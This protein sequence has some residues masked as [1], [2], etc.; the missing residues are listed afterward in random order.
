MKKP[1]LNLLVAFLLPA[2]TLAQGF[3]PSPV[4]WTTPVGSYTGSTGVSCG[5]FETNHI[6]SWYFEDLNGD[7]RP[8]LIVPTYVSG[9][10]IMMQWGVGSAPYW[11]VYLNTGSGFST[12]SITWNTPVGG[13]MNGSGVNTGYTD[14]N[15]DYT[16]YA[17][18][19][20]W[21]V[22]DMNDD[23]RP[24]LVV[25]S[26]TDANLISVQLG[27]GS[28]PHWKVYLNNGNG[29]DASPLTWPTPTGGRFDVSGS[30]YGYTYL[31]DLLGGWF[32]SERWNCMDMNGDNRPDLV[33]TSQFTNTTPD[34]TQPGA[35]L[36]PYWI[37]YY[38][39]GT[40]FDASGS[41]WYTPIGGYISTSSNSLGYVSTEFNQFGSAGSEDWTLRDMN[42]DH[43][44][45]LLVTSIYDAVNF[46]FAQYGAG[47]NPYWKV[48]YNTGNRFDT[49]T[50]VWS[51]PVGGFINSGGINFGYNETSGVNNGGNG[52]QVW[53]LC[54]LGGDQQPDLV[55]TSEFDFGS[56]SFYQFGT[57][58]S[59]YWKVCSNLGNGF[60][61][62]FTD[63][64]TPV[65]GMLISAVQ[66]P[67]Y[68]R[69][70]YNL[71]NENGTQVWDVADI[72]GDNSPD[73]IVT[74]E[75]QSA[76]SSFVQYNATTSPYWKVYLASPI[77][78]PE[79][80]TSENFIQAWPN[81]SPDV[82]R[83]ATTELKQPESV[84]V[85]DS[86]GR[87]VQAKNR[88]TESG[89]EVDLRNQPAGVYSVVIKH[90]NGTGHCRVVLTR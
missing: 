12:S 33:I 52:A 67:G 29:F 35:G 32:G 74:S 82:F 49:T 66:D 15:S 78:I 63:W 31:K 47:T 75:Y 28:S 13:Y 9:G 83:L 23:S 60:A 16:G 81:P 34:Y 38:N 56:G 72:N 5:F 20:T 68:F 3:S 87:Q 41:N 10:S 37:V 42:G 44:V 58:I 59:P 2:L 18:T 27:A 84:G 86:F 1:A 11:K 77:G 21:A 24:D 39:N 25:T 88:I 4:N 7:H 55:V 14:L 26:V 71:G 36:N 73:L 17:G 54:D 19:E 51:T 70:S 89:I 46:R 85:Y 22:K 76:V 69:F 61:G 57:G 48:F 80:G 8:D 64:S 50:H 30:S 65:G 45:D 6:L 43:L 40:G 79:L 53:N 90:L 62:T